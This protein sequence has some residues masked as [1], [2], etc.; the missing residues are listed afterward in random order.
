MNDDDALLLLTTRPLHSLF[1]SGHCKTL[2][3]KYEQLAKVFEAESSVVIANVDATVSPDLASRYGVSGYPTLKVF[4]PGVTEPVPYEG[5]R[6]LPELVSYMNEIAG[7]FRLADGSL[8]LNAGLVEAL[9][10]V[11]EEA[12]A[13]G[14]F[15]EAFVSR[16]TEVAADLEQPT[17]KH[18]LSFARKVVDKGEGYVEKELARLQGFVKSKSVTAEK[19]KN[20]SIRY[21][22]LR[23]FLKK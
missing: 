22:I 4:P 12:Q 19:K 17:V 23:M 6:E 3:P 14:G 20:F 11:V 18:Y 16:M 15:D 10:E 13:Q 8:A 21:N 2:A 1:L 9:N 7:T 5:A